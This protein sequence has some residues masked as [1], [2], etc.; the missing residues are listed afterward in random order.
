MRVRPWSS[1]FQ[2]KYCENYLKWYTPFGQI[3]TKKYQFWRFWGCTPT[4]LTHSDEIWHQGANL[5]LPPQAKFCIKNRLRGIPLL[6]K[7]ILNINNFSDFGGCK[8]TFEKCEQWN[9]TWVYRTWTPSPSL[10]LFKKSL[11]VICPLRKFFYQK[12]EIFAIFSYLSP[13]F[14]TDNVK[15]H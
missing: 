1:L 12:L 14:Y 11:R 4:F 3:Y 9:L 13:Y 7:C 6:G 10:I 8:P 15:I 5:G 2:A